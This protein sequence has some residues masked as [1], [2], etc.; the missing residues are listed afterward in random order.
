M[1]KGRFVNLK[2]RFVRFIKLSSRI[3]QSHHHR[4]SDQCDDQDCRKP[5]PFLTHRRTEGRRRGFPPKLPHQSSSTRLGR[6]RWRT[7]LSLTQRTSA[8][9]ATIPLRFSKDCRRNINYSVSPTG[10]VSCVFRG[11]PPVNPTEGVH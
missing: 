3:D 4:K 6:M 7:P 10:I 1:Q 2:R 11:I 8:P 9:Q 5:L